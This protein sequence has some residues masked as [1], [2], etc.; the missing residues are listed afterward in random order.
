MLEMSGKYT[1]CKIFNDVVEESALEQVQ[2]FLDHPAFE[3]CKTR[4]MPDIH[5]GAGTVIG[6]TVVLGDKVIPNVVGVDLS[7]GIM[8]VKLPVKELDLPLLDKVIH[9]VVPCGFDIHEYP[10]SYEMGCFKRFLE[11]IDGVCSEIG[12]D[13]NRVK[14]SIGTLGGGNHFIEVGKDESGSLWLTVHTGSRNFG[15]Q[16]AKYHQ[17]IAVENLKASKVDLSNIPPKE[18]EAYL[19]RQQKECVPKGMEYLE[20]RAAQKYL[21]H[22]KV[23]Q[24]F[25]DWNRVEIITN[26]LNGLEDVPSLG[27]GDMDVVESVESVHNY[28]DLDAGII[29]KGAISAKKDELVV[30]PWNMRDGLIIGKGKGNPDWNYSAPHGAGRNFSRTQARKAITLEEFKESMAGIYST[31]VVESTIDESPMAYKSS[32]DIEKYLEESVEIIHRVKPIYS[33]KAS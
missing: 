8:S 1:S 6:T 2:A 31:S 9:E 28:I 16:I 15:L 5:A 30:I 23:A 29:R 32:E 27:C 21:D 20:G 11:S 10:V 24:E 18:R 17:N 33:F 25:A 3:G 13:P 19:K 4:F 12:I 26:I 14:R 22:V 7:C